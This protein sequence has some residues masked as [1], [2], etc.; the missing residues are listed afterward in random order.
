MMFKFEVATLRKIVDAY[1]NVRANNLASPPPS[2][3][4][5]ILSNLENPLHPVHVLPLQ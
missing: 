4:S 2:A 1:K 3:F 5:M